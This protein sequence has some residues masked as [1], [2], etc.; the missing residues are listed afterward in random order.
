[1]RMLSGSHTPMLT[2]DR[3]QAQYF[4]ELLGR[5]REELDA[6]IDQLCVEVT[7]LERV[8]DS[9]AIRS[10]RRIIWAL[11]GEVH[12]IDRMLKTLR[13]RLLEQRPDGA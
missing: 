4:H 12:S 8:H 10:R 6:R 1:M 3:D 2:A 13:N 7:R 9:R 5:K 11:E